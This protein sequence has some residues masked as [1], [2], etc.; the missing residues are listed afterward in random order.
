VI[1]ICCKILEFPKL[2][3]QFYHNLLMV[4]DTFLTFK[5]PSVPPLQKE[6]ILGVKV[7]IQVIIPLTYK[8]IAK[9]FSYEHS[10]VR[11]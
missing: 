7:L 3:V 9:Y 2:N 4:G 5:A 6:H 10:F 8:C 1:Q 11:T